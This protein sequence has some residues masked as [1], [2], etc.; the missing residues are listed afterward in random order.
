[1]SCQTPVFTLLQTTISILY[2]Y[3]SKKFVLHYETYSHKA[4][5]IH[6]TIKCTHKHTHKHIQ[7][8]TNTHKHTQTHTNTHKQSETQTQTHT[9]C[10][11][12]MLTQHMRTTCTNTHFCIHVFTR[13]STHHTTLPPSSCDFQTPFCHF[14]HAIFV[15]HF[16]HKLFYDS[17]CL[18]DADFFQ[19]IVCRIFTRSLSSL[20]RDTNRPRVLWSVNDIGNV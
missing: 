13:T 7:T 20:P 11:H 6:I 17:Q 12:N 18:S 5:H 9:T 10:T 15:M 19:E 4:H 2:L 3:T 16:F 8:H 14:F 1:M